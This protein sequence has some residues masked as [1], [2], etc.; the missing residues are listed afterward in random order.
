MARDDGDDWRVKKPGEEKRGD[1]DPL[2]KNP[3]SD[4]SRKAVAAPRQEGQA[5][6]LQGQRRTRFGSVRWMAT[7]RMFRRTALRRRRAEEAF[8]HER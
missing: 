3:R 2:R 1:W 7:R 6:S 5:R 4:G 8:A